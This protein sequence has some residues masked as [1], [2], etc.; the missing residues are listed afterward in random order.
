MSLL[1]ISCTD[2]NNVRLAL[3]TD[4]RLFVLRGEDWN[5]LISM[6]YIMAIIRS[7]LLRH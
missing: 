3:S 1:D 5:Y 7:V 4:G 6:K 2:D